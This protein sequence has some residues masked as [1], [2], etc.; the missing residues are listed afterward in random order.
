M[1]QENKIWVH[2]QGIVLVPIPILTL[3]VCAT[4]ATLATPATV[5]AMGVAAA[6]G[7]VAI[8]TNAGVTQV[9]VDASRVIHG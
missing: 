9:E 3:G 4:P 2:V 6:H 1:L 7:V 8:L 5:A